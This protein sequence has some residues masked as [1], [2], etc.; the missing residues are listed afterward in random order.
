MATT[1]KPL[2]SGAAT[3]IT[4]TLAS[5]ASAT[6]QQAAGIDNGTNLYLEAHVTGKIKTGASG[7][8]ATG[9]ITVYVAGYDGTQY[10][11]NASGSNAS[12]TVDLQANLLPICTIAAT[13]NAT[14]Y[15][16]PSVYVASAA[17]WPFLPQKWTLIVYNGAGSA[18]DSTAG[19]F[20]LEY[21]GINTQGV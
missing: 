12:F 10:A 17:G 11:N 8:S 21:Q 19:N 5:L 18:L 6:Y 20:A 14:T 1:F 4:I 7:T 3:S 15:Y 13:A 9:F 2:Y 16:F